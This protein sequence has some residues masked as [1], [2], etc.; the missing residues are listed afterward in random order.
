LKTALETTTAVGE[1]EQKIMRE[2][3]TISDE[4]EATGN[5]ENP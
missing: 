1:A 2:G 5:E 3:Y 4:P